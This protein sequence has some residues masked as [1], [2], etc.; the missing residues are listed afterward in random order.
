ML[1]CTEDDVHSLN[2]KLI[3]LQW[4]FLNSTAIICF[5]VDKSHC[6]A[7][8]ITLGGYKMLWSR[9]NINVLYV[10]Q[11]LLFKII[12][13]CVILG[14]LLVTFK[15]DMSVY[16]FEPKI[17]VS[18]NLRKKKLKFW[19]FLTCLVLSRISTTYCKL[20]DYRSNL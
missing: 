7:K 6:M 4:L 13:L 16:G 19:S 14:F 20:F 3:Q 17:G 2:K 12:R 5:A 11:I 8:T 1:V 15:C 9:S 18:G 10:F